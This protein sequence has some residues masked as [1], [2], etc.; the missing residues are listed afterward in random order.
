LQVGDRHRAAPVVLEARAGR[1]AGR[2]RWSPCLP[3]S[4]GCSDSTYPAS[5]GHSGTPLESFLGT[6][7]IAEGGIWGSLTGV[8]VSVVAIF[9]IFGAVLN[10]G[11]AGQGF[12]NM[13]WPL[14]AVSRRVRQGVGAFVGAVRFDLR[15]SI[16]QCRLDRLL[17][18]AGHETARLS[19]FGSRRRWKRWRQAAGRS[20]RR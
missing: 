10:A 18:A 19:A 9:V 6:L 15:F 1:S 20:C 5:F 3:F 12:M 14:P 11:E 4:T 16:C 7:V 17:H 13:A 8:S 2:C